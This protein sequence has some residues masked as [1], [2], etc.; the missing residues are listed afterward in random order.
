MSRFS[1]GM[2]GTHCSGLLDQA[3]PVG[4]GGPHMVTPLLRP[5]NPPATA[6]KTAVCV[7]LTDE[8]MCFTSNS[9]ELT[10]THVISHILIL[11]HFHVILSVAAV[12]TVVVTSGIQ[13]RECSSFE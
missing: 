3:T 6:D 4:Y 2:V 1:E 5:K 11:G 12:K 9:A 7:F 13:Q 10:E 8:I